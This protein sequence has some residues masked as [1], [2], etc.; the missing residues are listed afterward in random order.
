M[1]PGDWASAKVWKER[2]KPSPITS[3]AWNNRIIRA[4]CSSFTPP[5]AAR[6][7]HQSLPG[8]ELKIISS[9]AHLSNVEQV[10][11]FNKAMIGFLDRV[12]KR[13]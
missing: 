12:S 5:E 3:R 7:I 13:N 9:A 4:I 10:D 11:E 6:A 1:K 8:S 2:A